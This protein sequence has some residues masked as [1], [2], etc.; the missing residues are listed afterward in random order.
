MDRVTEQ[1][2]DDLMRRRDVVTTRDAER[3][4]VGGDDLRAACA[5][6]QLV[7]VR[8]DAYTAAERWQQLD[9]A[10]QHRLRVLGAARRLREPVFTHDSAAALWRLPRIGP[11][12]DAVHVSLPHGV[13]NRSSAGVH[14]HATPGPVHGVVTVDGV[15]ATG[16]A[17]TV[18]DV[19][20][21]WDFASGLVAADHALHAGWAT[22]ARLAR[23]LEAA[24]VGRGVPRAR[25]VVDAAS[26]A[27]ESV[28][29]SLSRARM[30]ELGLPLPE[31]Q[32][33]VEDGD[34]FVGRVDFWWADLGLVG[35]FDGR[36]KYRAGGAADDRAVEDR[37]WAEKLR[38]D[39]LRALGLRV[40]RWTWDTALHAD[41]LLAVLRAAGLHPT[42]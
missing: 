33:R 21:T 3:A 5:A 13:G 37:V 38:E 31:L 29:E 17:R 42:T 39:R 10:G 20:R 7:R 1:A 11:W 4:G 35:E 14:R 19:A 36:L 8:V 28:G 23:E 6:G 25:R 15:R 34:G 9:G 24:G 26:A 2:L 16:T 41:R 40:V 18:L 32:H 30:I 27:S 22:A 12:P